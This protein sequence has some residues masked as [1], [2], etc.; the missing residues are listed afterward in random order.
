M[1]GVKVRA[2]RRVAGRMSAVAEQMASIQ[3]CKN[4]DV[5]PARLTRRR[6]QSVTKLA[7]TFALSQS[8]R[9]ALHVEVAVHS[10]GDSCGHQQIV[11]SLACGRNVYHNLVAASRFAWDASGLAMIEAHVKH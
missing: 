10:T 6:W 2:W 7:C 4:M 5:T 1:G 11:R 8:S 3:R 9:P